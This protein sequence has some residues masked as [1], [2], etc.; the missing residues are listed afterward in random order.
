MAQDLIPKDWPHLKGYWKFQNIKD[1]T[2][3]TVGNKLILVGTHQQVSGPAYG[4][5]AIRI[6]VGSYYKCA[7]GIAPNGGGDSV[8]QYT[9][10]FDFKVLNFKKWHTFFQTD[11]T[12]ANDGECFIRPITGSKPAR[13]GTATTGYTPDS[14]NANQWYRLVISVNLNNFYRYYINGKLWLEGDTQEVDG[15]FALLPQILFFA[16]NDKEDDTIDVASVAIFDTC[17]SSKDIAK[18]GT[19]EPCI[20]N[21]P[22]VNLGIDTTLC[23]NFTLNLD[24]GANYIKYQWSTGNKLPFEIID[25]NTLGTGK[26]QVWVKVTDRNGCTGGDTIN[27]TYLALPKVDLGK[28]TALCKG[29][30]LKLTGGTD[31]SNTYQWKLLP[32]GTI[33][34]SSNFITV[35]S[36]GIYSVSVTNTSKCQNTDTIDVVVN[37][38]PAKPKINIIGNTSLCKGDSVRLEGPGSYT[39]YNWSNGTKVQSFYTGKIESVTLKV[40]DANGCVSPASDTIKIKVNNLPAAPVIQLSG[41]STF[42]DG[43]SV[44]MTV[45]SGY[46]QYIWQDGI[47]DYRRVVKKPTIYKVFVKDS[48][49][50]I[51]PVS[52]SVFVEVLASPPKPTISISG[53]TTFCEGKS[54]KLSSSSTHNGYLWTDSTKTT[55]IIVT[56]GGNYGLKVKDL[57]GCYSPWSELVTITVNPIPPKPKVVVGI[58]DSLQSNT[59]AERYKWFLN[60][61]EIRD[62]VKT[63][64]AIHTGFFQVKVAEKACWSKTSDSLYYK[65]LWINKQN[66]GEL[67]L[68]IVPNPVNSQMEIHFENGIAS[69]FVFTSIY[70]GHGKN[71]MELKTRYSEEIL[72]NT[73]SLGKGIYFVKVISG[74]NTFGSRFEKL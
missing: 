33:I 42:C 12:N 71:V 19:I 52:N 2:K 59:I 14:I 37:K 34:S 26:K 10:M 72:I 31:L 21:P 3:P 46:K 18:I 36:S 73:E 51:S 56:K 8:N 54:T 48:N 69:G 32:K 16:D 6:A 47:G 45:T 57:N 62:T 9:L 27:I 25:A 30:T 39:T 41:N 40:T 7:H 15:R 28:D 44:V 22:K 43:D 53:A 58:K 1:L 63:I 74:K 23:A 61:V 38:N 17:L 67:K 20:A 50:C 64:Y 5:T 49:N 60:G 11:T 55:D 65:N 24:A 70:D 4:D 29:Q 35:D 66:N 13:I 68:V